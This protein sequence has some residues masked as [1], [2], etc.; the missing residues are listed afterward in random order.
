MIVVQGPAAG[1]G[2]EPGPARRGGRVRRRGRQGVRRARRR[3]RARRAEDD[4][5]TRTRRWPARCARSGVEDLDPRDGPDSP[6]PPPP[7]CA[8]PP[9]AAPCPTPW[10]ARCWPTPTAGRSRSVPDGP[11]G[12][13]TATCSTSGG[14][15]LDGPAD[16][17]TAPRRRPPARH[18]AR[19]R[20]SPTWSRDERG[21]RTRRGRPTWPCTWRSPPG[22]CSGRSTGPW[23]W[24]SST[25]TGASSSASRSPP[26]S[27]CSSSWPTPPWP[28][29]ACGS[30]PTSRCGGSPATLA[31]RRP[32]PA[33]A[34]P[35]RGPG[36]AA[37]QPAAP[38]RRPG[39]ATSTTSP[40]SPAWSSPPCACPGAPSARPPSWPPP[41]PGTASTA[42]SPRR[43]RRV[44]TFEGPPLDEPRGMGAL[45]LG[46]FLDEV[47]ERFGRNEALVFDRGGDTVRWTY[48]DL[49]REAR[50]IGR[51]LVADGVEPGDAV[52]ILMGNRPRRWRPSSARPGRRGGRAAVDRSPRGPS[53][54]T[55]W[56]GPRSPWS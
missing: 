36:G 22:R 34:R 32:R 28:W 43:G 8:R 52:G 44:T 6:S 5:A 29:P 45:T 33:G 12:S 42:C 10:P 4:P 53:W 26:S 2:R 23:S 7:R 48:A 9:A 17:G 1:G 16:G 51:R 55:C 56:S 46:G 14:R 35:R 13:T 50:R 15:P 31:G 11:P 3:R 40:S 37:H 38:R 54:P 24:R 25:S 18:P 41:S 49:D 39:C 21:R 20:S 30:W 19:D 47:A 27:P